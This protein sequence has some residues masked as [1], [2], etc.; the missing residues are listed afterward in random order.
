MVSLDKPDLEKK[1]LKMKNQD[2]QET[3]YINSSGR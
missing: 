3:A 1:S 2:F